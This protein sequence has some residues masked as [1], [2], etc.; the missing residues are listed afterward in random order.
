MRVPLAAWLMLGVDNMKTSL[1]GREPLNAAAEP[2]SDLV[3]TDVFDVTKSVRAKNRGDASRLESAGPTF[4]DFLQLFSP[5]RYQF[6]HLFWE[7]LGGLHVVEHHL[8][9]LD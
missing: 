5:L 2:R 6:P 1:S 3:E 4:I 9:V 7:C 8:R